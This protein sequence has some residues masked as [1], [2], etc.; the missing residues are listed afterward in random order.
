MQLVLIADKISRD[1]FE[2]PCMVSMENRIYSEKFTLFL[3]K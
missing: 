1:S 3:P 2:A